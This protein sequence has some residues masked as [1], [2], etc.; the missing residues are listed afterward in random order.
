MDLVKIIVERAGKDHPGLT[1]VL[2]G[3]VAFVAASWV[4]WTYVEARARESKRPFL[5]KQLELYFEACEVTATMASDTSE[6]ERVDKAEIRFRQLYWGELALVETNDVERIMEAFANVFAEVSSSP[7]A[8]QFR[9]SLL[10]ELAYQLAH[11]C[12]TSIAKGW[13]F[14]T[15]SRLSTVR[16]ILGTKQ[17]SRTKKRPPA[18]S[19]PSTDLGPE[20]KAPLLLEADFS[21]VFREADF[22]DKLNRLKNLGGNSPA[23]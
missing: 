12:R 17:S 14:R 9:R 5:E 6:R 20:Q 19:T 23:R 13:G 4:V 18:Q 2:A 16:E 7:V 21:R 3:V 1:L 15:R 8:V 10:T 22:C 11:A